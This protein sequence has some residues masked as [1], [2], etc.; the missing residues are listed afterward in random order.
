VP[1]EDQ[2]LLLASGKT[3]MS[4]RFR[5]LR[6]EPLPA[7][8][9]VVIGAGIGGLLCANL[10]SRAGLRVL[11][12]EQHYMAGGYCST[13][14][15]KGF[16]F[17]AATHFYPL[18]GNPATI[19]GKVLTAIGA[20]TQWIQMDPVDQFHFPD[21]TRFSV[22]A[23]FS[24]YTARLKQEFPDESHA[25]DSFF[26]VVQ[27]VY[28]LGLLR[29]FRGRPTEQ[30]QPYLTLSVQEVLDCH[31]RNPK[32]KL[33]LTADTGHW[34]SPPERT[35]F[36]FDSMLRLAY[37][38]GN[39][40]PRGGSQAFSDELA[41]RFEETGGHI[42]M[43]SLVTRI[44]ARDEKACGVEVE[45]G[46][47]SSRRRITVRAEHIISNAD[48]LQTMERL[49]PNPD[50]D[51]IAT[52]KQLR[53]SLPCFVMH[54]GLRGI[55]TRVLE[56]VQ[57]YHW[58]SWNA[59]HVATDAFKIFVPTLFD[60]GVA[61]PGGHIV[62]V[63]KIT[64]ID[65][66]SIEDWGAHKAAV[67]KYLTD[68]LERVIPGFSNGVVVKLSASALTSYRF[69]LNHC[70][71]ML[72][73]ELSPNQLG[74]ARPD[75]I[76]PVDNLYFVGHWTQPGGGITPVMVSAMKVAQLITGVRESQISSTSVSLPISP[77]LIPSTSAMAV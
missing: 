31:F 52:L 36:I 40:Y 29:F 67:E 17:D 76:G 8:D 16:L 75:V 55:P 11:L 38:L 41:A 14:K 48:L 73:W 70:G 46:I 61:P 44:Q 45:T 74:E 77:T 1:R 4:R 22:P 43:S 13:F 64:N 2:P 19:T 39:Y 56:E 9:A 53:P 47:G 7:Y 32:L 60:A 23:D 33:L 5:S 63:Q 57:G 62:I 3:S 26:A 27:R 34:G 59:N 49:I 25:I 12:V 69:T 24:S 68:N 42:L 18:L 30:L 51:Y 37:F 58:S 28:L 15:R 6:T 20:N 72:G 54:V 21:G 10:L 65:Y 71:A 66:H 50:P 35:S